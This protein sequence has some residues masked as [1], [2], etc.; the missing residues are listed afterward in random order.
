MKLTL[1]KRGDY[2]IRIVLYMAE[3]DPGYKATSS[4]FADGCDIPFGPIQ[5]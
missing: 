3:R 2:G 5:I 1:S 4:E